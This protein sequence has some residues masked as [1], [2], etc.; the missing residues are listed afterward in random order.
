MRKIAEIIQNSGTFLMYRGYDPEA[1][2]EHANDP[3]AK[4]MIVFATSEEFLIDLREH[5]SDYVV[6]YTIPKST[7]DL[8]LISK[9]AANMDVPWTPIAGPD[10]GKDGVFD[11]GDLTIEDFYG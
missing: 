11:G 5:H 6:M 10:M 4:M 2:E 1:V 9:F 7:T 3:G 8:E